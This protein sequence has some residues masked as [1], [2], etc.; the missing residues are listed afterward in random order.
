LRNAR[1]W[2]TQRLD[3]T[4]APDLSY[5]LLTV[6]LD[7]ATNPDALAAQLWG[8]GAVGIE[9]LPGAL[10]A[11]FESA[12]EAQNA[13]TLPGAGQPEVYADTVGLDAAR[14]LLVVE[15]AGLFAIHPPWLA[16]P[17]DVIGIEIDPGHAFGSGSHA[18]TRLALGLITSDRVKGQH[19]LDLGCGTG[20]LA[21]AAARLGASV[22]AVDIDPAAVAATLANVERNGVGDRVEVHRG[23][24]DH[25]QYNAAPDISPLD[26][27]DFD[28][29][30]VN[31]TIDLHEMLAPRRSSWPPVIIVA[32]LLDGP[33]LERAALTYG[34]A[35]TEQLVDGDWV[36]AV[37]T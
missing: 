35:I 34:R 6:A 27:A 14:D 2:P 20:V 24:A 29:A 18:S 30:I 15:H 25:S 13:A 26:S 9:E 12:E 8:Y 37:L 4:A 1:T 21:I 7:E 23:S 31:V 3:L 32:G 10:R 17:A 22:V 28:L 11:A 36:G 19:V 5:F 33:Q 16:P